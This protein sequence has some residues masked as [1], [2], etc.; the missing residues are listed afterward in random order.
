MAGGLPTRFSSTEGIDACWLIEPRPDPPSA[1]ERCDPALVAEKAAWSLDATSFESGVNEVRRR[2]AAGDVYQVNL[3]RRLTV[4]VSGEFVDSFVEAA[5]AG[6]VPDYLAT[7]ESAGSEL[8]CASMELLLCRRGDKLATRPIKGT[9]PRGTDHDSDRRMMR[10][11]ETD[12]KERSELAMIVDLERNDLGRICRVGSVTVVDPG[13]VRSFPAVHHLVASVEGRA[14]GDVPWWKMLSVML[15]GGSVTGC[16]KRAAM[17]VVADLEPMSRGPFTG[18]LGV[19]AGD[20]D[21]ELALPIRTAWRTQ[22]VL[23]VA[24]GCGIVWHSDPE[25]E[26]RESRLKIGR[27]LELLGLPA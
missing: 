7:F 19:V 12:S 3:C 21:L 16:P 20:G 24:A 2:I 13:S 8:V 25:S 4:P 18:A 14:R 5:S 17:S 26:E 9:R 6:G 27:W 22:G 10:D 23:N 11:L 15:P 1:R